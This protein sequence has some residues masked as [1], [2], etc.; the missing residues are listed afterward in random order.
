MCKLYAFA[1]ILVS[2][3]LF[4]EVQGRVLGRFR[5][6]GTGL[7]HA[8]AV[9]S[10]YKKT[11]K[12]EATYYGEYPG[13]GACS[14]DPLSP[15][16]SQPGWIRVAAGYED[17]QGSLG[18][19]MCLEIK[20]SGKGSGSDPVTG[21]LKGV[22]HDLCGGCKQGDLDLFVPG[23]GR[24]DITFTAIDC[25]TVPGN[26]GNLMLR[27]TGSDPW[28]I[29]LQARNTR[30]PVAGI[31]VVKNN[32]ISCLLRVGDNYFVG[33]SQGVFDFPM[34][35]RLTAVTG[36]QKEVTIPSLKNDENVITDV[37]FTGHNTGDGPD[38]IKCMGQGNKPPYP[39]GGM[40][41][42]EGSGPSSPSTGATPAPP[43]P[44]TSPPSS[45]TGGTGVR[46]TP[47]IRDNFCEGK[48]GG[49]FPDPDDCRGFIICNH[50]NTH[51]MKCE[52]G[53]MF[54]PKGMNCDLPER[55]NC[56]ARKQDDLISPAFK[57]SDQD[58]VVNMGRGDMGV[59]NMKEFES[60][61]TPQ[62]V[63]PIPV[64][65]RLKNRNFGQM[66][67]AATQQ[68]RIMSQ[69]VNDSEEHHQSFM[70]TI[71]LTLRPGT[72]GAPPA[73]D[74]A[75]VTQSQQ[76]PLG[77]N[78]ESK[79]VSHHSSSF[80]V[81]IGG[82][83]K[84]DDMQYSDAPKHVVKVQIGGNK[85]ESDSQVNDNVDGKA[86][87]TLEV[88][89]GG[90]KIQAHVEPGKTAGSKIADE[91][92]SLSSGRPSV[93]VSVHHP[94]PSGTTAGLNDASSE[95]KGQQTPIN[96]FINT[97][98]A[99]SG[100]SMDQ[101]AHD[102]ATEN[103]QVQKLEDHTATPLVSK[104]TE[105]SGDQKEKSNDMAPV[106]YHPD[107]FCAQQATCNDI[108]AVNNVVSQALG[109]PNSAVNFPIQLLSSAPTHADDNKLSLGTEGKGLEG[110]PALTEPAFEQS[111]SAQGL[112]VIPSTSS[113]STATE[114]QTDLQPLELPSDQAKKLGKKIEESTVP[115][116]SNEGNVNTDAGTS[117]T[118]F[119]SEKS[120]ENYPAEQKQSLGT[121]EIP[122][123]VPDTSPQNYQG[124]YISDIPPKQAQST[125]QEQNRP[126][127]SYLKAVAA[128]VMSH[129]IN[130]S[131]QSVVK[132]SVD[133]S[134]PVQGTSQMAP[135]DANGLPPMVHQ[136][137]DDLTQDDKKKEETDGKEDKGAKEE[138][139]GSNEKDE[140]N[141]KGEEKD[142]G[143]E[144]KG[145]D[146]E[147]RKEKENKH[148]KVEKGNQDGEGKERKD[149]KDKN[150]EDGKGE[151]KDKEDKKG[152]DKEDNEKEQKEEKGDKD[153]EGKERKDE[154]DK[155]GEDGKGGDKDKEDKEGKNKEDNEKEKEKKGKDE[156][157]EKEGKE[158]KEDK[159]EKDSDG[160][161]QRPSL[162]LV[163]QQASDGSTELQVT[164]NHMNNQQRNGKL[165]DGQKGNKMPTIGITIKGK[166]GPDHHI[167]FS[168]RHGMLDHKGHH[169]HHHE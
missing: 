127:E 54:N 125:I 164:G 39:S 8:Q 50:G 78:T 110:R 137:T 159:D 126:L 89:F 44:T 145:K 121:E 113:E 93:V 131:V 22:V 157:D 169:T 87:P 142:K 60:A 35:V 141:T 17:F 46:P 80:H 101:N 1:F 2:A 7:P 36:E 30:V 12:G 14:L 120:K 64:E 70:P 42:G 97:K 135:S 99:Q 66:A 32:N 52:P 116:I 28:Y 123:I 55:V 9:Y 144:D 140:K 150:G 106:A 77:V 31:E 4:F 132:G 40:A 29:K 149:E 154:K 118:E 115:G 114:S 91:S 143:K 48:H 20:G 156:K 153:G 136:R 109:P 25:P 128:H 62:E 18:C 11:S 112:G 13:G 111:K 63:E 162:D 56:G 138:E 108:G 67:N 53:L 98:K 21:T 83:E 37:Q 96:V 85:K 43:A 51:R 119:P 34:K 81:N 130:P 100:Y 152:K 72:A 16:A 146:G 166:G 133:A 168:K 107:P 6:S 88:S 27:F 147:E 158:G 24:W 19:G 5:R 102:F 68:A 161:S 82:N 47:P 26:D 84:S 73:T 160:S 148:G 79:Q 38:N 57:L 104:E 23:D 103:N 15:L 41:P 58:T 151:D 59:V 92:S 65:E 90:S 155:N 10:R 69:A 61:S 134:S 165:M 94:R 74:F 49:T 124:V 95:S 33:K 163:V 105:S 129:M 139:K 76:E 117:Q 86:R 167:L 3:V 122:D 71:K 75:G 45:G